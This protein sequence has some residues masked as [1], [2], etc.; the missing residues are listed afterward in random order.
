MIKIGHYQ[1]CFMDLF[2]DVN[3]KLSAAKLWFHVAN[4][5]MSKVILTQ[6]VISWDIFAAYGAICGGS[7][8]ATAWLKVK[9]GAQEQPTEKENL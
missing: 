2:V 9:Y 5:I 4:V 1:I 7:H 8:R 6:A 3:G